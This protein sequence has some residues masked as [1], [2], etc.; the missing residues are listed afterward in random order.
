[1]NARS[2]GRTGLGA[3]L[4]AMYLREFQ[5]TPS[6]QAVTGALSIFVGGCLK[7]EVRQQL[8]GLTVLSSA[9]ADQVYAAIPAVESIHGVTQAEILALFDRE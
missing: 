8:F 7:E 9:T 3:T 5:I 4:L 1:M 2:L 6:Q